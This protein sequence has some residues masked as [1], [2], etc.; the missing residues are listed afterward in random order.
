MSEVYVQSYKYIWRTRM[1]LLLFA[2]YWY[3]GYHTIF[4]SQPRTSMRHHRI[5]FNNPCRRSLCIRTR[6]PILKHNND[7]KPHW[8]QNCHHDRH[9]NHNKRSQ[10]DQH[11]LATS[12]ITTTARPCQRHQPQQRTHKPLS[13]T[14]SHCHPRRN[15]DRAVATALASAIATT[16][17]T[18]TATTTSP[19]Y[20]QLPLPPL[21][22]KTTAATMATTATD[23]H[24]SCQDNWQLANA[25]VI[26]PPYPGRRHSLSGSV[27]PYAL[28]GTYRQK[29]YQRQRLR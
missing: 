17:A 14:A 2:Y 20:H 4:I 23:T 27:N 22:T 8:Q 28:N 26:N 15:H 24:Q 3:A 9:R 6:P 19:S 18:A 16:T 11:R 1:Q 21:T 7:H 10:P 13:S 25:A 12:A 29:I 5:T